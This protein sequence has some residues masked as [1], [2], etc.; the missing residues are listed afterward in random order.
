MNSQAS[1]HILVVDDDLSHLKILRTIVTSWGYQA[2]EADDGS[3]Q[4]PET[5][6]A[7]ALERDISK[8]QSELDQ[9]R[10]DYDSQAENTGPDYDRGYGGYGSMMGCGPGGGGYCMQ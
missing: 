6:K 5:G 9:K 3:R 8:L 4:T 1:S 7:A 2:T 10:L